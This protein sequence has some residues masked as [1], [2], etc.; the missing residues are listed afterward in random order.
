MFLNMLDDNFPVSV[1]SISGN[2]HKP[3][4]DR[5][6]E[7]G[8]VQSLS[9]VQLFT[10][11]WTAACQASLS[12]TNSWTCSN[13]YPFIGG[14]NQPSYPLS[15][16]SPPA[17]NLPQHQGLLATKKS[18]PIYLGMLKLGLYNLPFLYFFVSGFPFDSGSRRNQRKIWKQSLRRRDFVSPL[19]LAVPYNIAPT[20]TEVRV[21]PPVCSGL[22]NEH[23]CTL[24][25]YPSFKTWMSRRPL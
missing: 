8:S 21:L 5:Y 25:M 18:L 10:T 19:L 22:W 12:V 1:D 3:F 16:A 9:H 13:S 15:S 20:A 2:N 24:Q 14:A 11:S 23:Q 6:D 4:N 7:Q 17:F